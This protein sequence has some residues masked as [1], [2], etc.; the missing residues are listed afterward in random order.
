[1][2]IRSDI[3]KFMS[4]AEA[5]QFVADFLEDELPR[6]L[7]RVQEDLVVTILH[8]VRHESLST[9]GTVLF[10][11]SKTPIGAYGHYHGT[12]RKAR[13]L[14][15]DKVNLTFTG[16][17]LLDFN[18]TEQSET[19]VGIGFLSQESALKAEDNEKYY[20]DEIFDPS[21]KEE[22]ETLEWAEDRLFSILNRM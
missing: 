19:E 22:L 17:M 9:N 3:L 13:G 20:E 11:K 21:R 12:A 14:R 6:E 18:L 16:R 8:R 15:V 4:D 5:Y 1:M 10:T 7:L 2:I